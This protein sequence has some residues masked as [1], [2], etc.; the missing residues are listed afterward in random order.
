M[1]V[2][3]DGLS[4]FHDRAQAVISILIIILWGQVVFIALFCKIYKPRLSPAEYISIGSAGWVMPVSMMAVFL[5]FIRLWFGETA[6]KLLAVLAVA[7][8]VLSL[9]Y[10]KNL[11]YA[12]IV[13]I[14][15]FL[16]FFILQL[17][18]IS[19]LALPMY[20]DSAE[21]YRIIKHMLSLF[22]AIPVTFPSINYYHIGFHLIIAELAK[23]FDLNIVDAMLVFGQ[24]VLA[25]LPFSLYFI[26]RR[27]SGSIGVAIFTCLLAGF[28]WHMPS[29]LINW[30][31]YPALLSLVCIL[32][33]VNVF[34]LYNK[35]DNRGTLLVYLI[36]AVLISAFI[37]SRTL[38]VYGF[39][40]IFFLAAFWPGRSSTQVNRMAFPLFLFFLAM[41]IWM[42]RNNPV[43]S[44][45]ISG[46]LQRD[47]W[48]LF[49]TL[50]LLPFA[51]FY[52]PVQ[53]FIL[54]GSLTMIIF[55]LFVPIPLPNLGFLT[56]LDRPYI[57]MLLYLSLSLLSGFGL[58]G[59]L[60]ALK[61]INVYK[62]QFE[63]IV[64]ILFTGL[65]VWNISIN[66]GFYP[67]DCCQIVTRDDLAALH[68]INISVPDKAVFFVAS[69]QLNVTTHEQ[70]SLPAGVDGGVWVDPLTSR[71]I[72]YLGDDLKFNALNVHDQICGTE[73]SYIYVGGM[74][75]SF[76]TTQLDQLP[77]WYKLV[78]ALPHVRIYQGIG[79]L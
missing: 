22:D 34:Y 61:K 28:G 69:V 56:L 45:L 51:V 10:I 48:M 62:K 47:K 54:L 50:V 6:E 30:G 78:F 75:K 16:S 63:Y 74:P 8:F 70:T 53:A 17:A 77:E 68:W 66:H 12:F 44:P 39:I 41:E 49:L 33:V 57:Q 43:L 14:P 76:D 60:Q 38:V 19:I 37:H 58:A 64:T 23:L 15:I 20:F 3:T 21:H 4:V 11:F 42:V 55:G 52:F 26:T 18:F 31:K 5:F 7:A 59:F 25:V 35:G 73:E 79:C 67:S 29:H 40:A 72:I 46:Y 32:L 1:D 24:V 65:I 36:F 13:Y 2:I 27:G 71:K 9:V